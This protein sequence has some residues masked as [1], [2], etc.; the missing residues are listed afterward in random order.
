MASYLFVVTSASLV[1]RHLGTLRCSS[2]DEMMAFVEWCGGQIII[3]HNYFSEYDKGKG[4]AKELIVY[5]DY[6]E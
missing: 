1:R 2:L 6:V 3:G 4:C 5:D